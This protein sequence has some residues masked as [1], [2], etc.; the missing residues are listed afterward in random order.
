MGDG[1]HWWSNVKLWRDMCEAAI[2]YSLPPTLT[3]DPASAWSATFPRG[4]WC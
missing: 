4:S 1:K 3:Y 2:Y